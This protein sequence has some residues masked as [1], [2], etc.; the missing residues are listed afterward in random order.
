MKRGAVLT[1]LLWLVVGGVAEPRCA[2]AQEDAVGDLFDVSV[3][4]AIE[5]GVTALTAA[6]K[7]PPDAAHRSAGIAL[8]YPLGMRALM[9]Y[10][11][12]ESGVSV[13]APEILQ[14][15]SEMEQLPLKN[16]YSVALYVLALDACW[17]HGHFE[18]S[19][20]RGLRKR[21]RRSVRWLV[22]SRQKGEGIWG[23]TPVRSK[24]RN[25]HEWV[26]F[27]ITQFVALALGVGAQR[28]EAVPSTVWE[29]LLRAYEQQG[30]P[31]AEETRIRCE[32]PGW[33]DQRGETSKKPDDEL[34]SF[35][36]DGFELR[37][38]AVG[39]PYRPRWNLPPWNIHRYSYSMVAAA[40]SSLVVVRE[41]MGTKATRSTRRRID[42]LIVGGMLT[43]VRDW[44]TLGPSRTDTIWR[45]YFYTIYSLEKALDLGGVETLGGI[46]WYRSQARVLITDQRDDGSWG[47]NSRSLAADREF[48]TVST[49]FAL[50][51]LGRATKALRVT[52]VV[53]VV[54]FGG[55]NDDDDAP[56][57]VHV[58]RLG[59][60]VDVREAF[61]RLQKERTRELLDVATEI[62]GA[63]PPYQRPY[64]LDQVAQ[65][66]NGSG[67]AVDRFALQ[68]VEEITGLTGTTDRERLRGWISSYKILHR[69]GS[70][71]SVAAIPEIGQMLTDASPPLAVVALTTLERIGS[72]DAVPHLLDALR[73]PSVKVRA[74]AH[75]ALLAL[76]LEPST[77]SV[78][79]EAGP[80]SAWWTARW[81]ERGSDLRARRQW[82][83]LRQ[84][85]EQAATPGDR[86]R[87][88]AAIVALG[89]WVLPKVDA[90]LQRDSF[91]FD[92]ILVREALTGERRGI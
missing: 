6:L 57:K 51:F 90:I 33:W 20:L 23:Y 85:L 63:V 3:E 64:L 49:A 72:L 83:G 67:D 24:K 27:S 71:R 78:T 15:F 66:R 22:A 44:G 13:K 62:V 31:I 53:P 65:L 32:G 59:G 69:W 36:G 30:V 56:T 75:R 82:D 77:P 38:V 26:D 92:W 40:T 86:A 2:A 55:S 21:L 91:L 34:V 61:A 4:M 47:R 8:Q 60:M 25:L 7:A 16:T 17:R 46:D 35:E 43:L 11:L 68:R 70:R 9:A 73:S 88:R 76:T 81:H 74:R 19:E 41:A 10:A 84:E 28:G 48:D 39:W 1:L 89:E 87:V 45:N 79:M 80:L 54:T 42:R 14:L 50:L 5:K 58:A 52:P 29:E 37:G 12:V 18:E